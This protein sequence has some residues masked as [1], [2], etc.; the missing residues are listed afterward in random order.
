MK[1]TPEL[2]G[3][4]GILILTSLSAASLLPDAYYR[5]NRRDGQ[6]WPY[7]V[8]GD[9][10]GS[11]V[12]YNNDVLYDDNKDDCLRTKESHG[13][14]MEADET[15]I[16]HDP[17]GLRDAACSGSTLGD[18]FL[19]QHQMGKVGNPDVVIMTSGG[20][21]AGFGHIVDVC[22]YHSD[23]THYYGN[24]YWNDPDRSGECAKA[25][26]DALEYITNPDKMKFDLT[27]TLK[28][29]FNDPAVSG[30]P[31]FLLYLTGYAQFFGTDYDP[32]CDSEY[33]SIPT[34]NP[35]NIDPYLS[36]NLRQDFNDHVSKVNDLYKATAESD[37]YKAKVRY[38]DVD[39]R[40]AGHRFCEPGSNY[41]EQ[42]NKDTHFDKVYLWN[43]NYPWQITGQGA[44]SPAAA[45][46]NVTAQ[47][48]QDAFNGQSI[49]AWNSGSG[50]GGNKPENGWRLRP[51]HPRYTGYTAIKNA[52]FAQLKIDG[53]PK[54]N[55]TSTTNSTSTASPSS[56]T[57]TAPAPSC[58]HVDDGTKCQCTDGSTPEPDE[59]N[60]CCLYNQPN[61][62]D[63]CFA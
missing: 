62:N 63:Q 57:S 23:P 2:K 3:V 6:A 59:D 41:Q 25:L 26:D 55:P 42:I 36:K 30:N 4:I 54:Q 45:E 44:P 7:G 12:S 48:A 53:R 17:S 38:I 27:E 39:S 10:W 50:G 56:T 61:N 5:L 9:S 29:L 32:W 21:N 31:D 47:E 19:G 34:I 16:G 58:S 11:G 35:S 43:L 8:I 24:P 49:T 1:S 33:W 18:I 40:F 60:R 28:D 46:G 15:W 52:I 20:N 51:F 13:P 22:I 37:E 14:Q